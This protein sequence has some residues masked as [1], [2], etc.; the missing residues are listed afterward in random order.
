MNIGVATMK[1]T[2][3]MR[4]SAENKSN[5]SEAGLSAIQNIARRG[6]GRYALP[7]IKRWVRVA[8]VVGLT[9]GER[10]KWTISTEAEGSSGSHS[11]VEKA[12][13][14]KSFKT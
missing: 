11:K 2:E 4:N 6:E 8:D 9:I 10:F 14:G 5:V 12:I 13:T 1:R 3:T 7:S